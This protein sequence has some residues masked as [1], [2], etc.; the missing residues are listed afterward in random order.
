[1]KK[2]IWDPQIMVDNL[3]T[4]GKY[5]AAI[6]LMLSLTLCPAAWI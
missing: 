4:I 5:I 3:K 2:Y 1:M 6:L